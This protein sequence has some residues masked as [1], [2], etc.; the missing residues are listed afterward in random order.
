MV[1]FGSSALWIGPDEIADNGVVIAAFDR[2]ARPISHAVDDKPS[3]HIVVA[4]DAQAVMSENLGTVNLDSVVPLAC[5]NDNSRIVSDISK[6]ILD[7]ASRPGRWFA[8]TSARRNVPAGAF[9]SFP[10]SA[11][12]V[13]TKVLS[14]CCPVIGCISG[15]LSVSA[16]APASDRVRT[17]PTPN[18]I[19]VIFLKL[20]IISYLIPSDRLNYTFSIGFN[21]WENR[22]SRFRV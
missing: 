14:A 19:V 18:N 7:Q 10:L 16:R 4:R 12:L 2:N 17:M 21:E 1:R 20:M 22:Y 6:V 15:G 9:A 3:N 13:T 8:S 11:V 5:V